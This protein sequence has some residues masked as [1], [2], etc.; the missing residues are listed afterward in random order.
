MSGIFGLLRR[1]GGPADPSW[2]SAMQAAMAFYG[3]DGQSCWA[4]GCVGLGFLLKEV[5]PEDRHER[6]PYRVPRGHVVASARL[7]NRGALLE[8]FQ[9]PGP[10]ASTTPDGLL[11]ALAFDRWG[12]DCPQHLEGD[13][14]LAGWDF[15]EQRL[16]LARDGCGLTSLYFL[17]GPGYFA[18][19]S[20]LK[21]LLALP[22]VKKAPD[23]LRMAQVLVA[24][25][26]DEELTAYEACHR[27]PFGVAM[28]VDTQGQQKSWR[29]WEPW[30]RPPLDYAKDED[31]VEAF[32]EHYTRAVRSRLRGTGPVAA[33]LSAGM[34]SGSV[35]ALAAPL[36]AAQGR[37]L[38]AY[39]SVPLHPPDGAGPTR[40]GNEWEVAHLTAGLAGSNVHH[41][42]M[43]AAHHTVLEGIRYVLGVHDGPGHASANHYW[44]QAIGE[45][46]RQDGM[47]TLLLGMF[48]NA[49]VSWTGHGSALLALKQGDPALAFRLLKL[50]LHH[51][52]ATLKRQVLSPLAYP[53]RKLQRQRHQGRQ[54]PW[55]SYAAIRAEFALQQELRARMAQAGHYPDFL[56]PPW[57]DTHYRFYSHGWSP[58]NGIWTELSPSLG[59]AGLD[60]TADQAL[61]AFIWSVPDDQ[62]L[63]DGASRA[64]LRRTFKGRLPEAVLRPTG[65]GLQAADLGHRVL[66]EREA[67]R[68]VLRAL[69]RSDLAQTVLDLP[70][71]EATLEAL[72]R[73]VTPESTQAAACILLRGLGVGLF[74]LQFEGGDSPQREG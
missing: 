19:A 24:W 64:L 74:L 53:V 72:E 68:E 12:R 20:S 49:S 41:V 69:A 48:G 1:D 9:V 71:M 23:L 56:F 44:V 60:P 16:L 27:L 57:H 11:A 2:L 70:R 42:P 3:P 13:W 54:Q 14:A 58:A 29:H 52:W 37:G 67:M 38:T 35:V 66:Q 28:E 31:Y 61:N 15:Q 6:Q 46:A 22:G 30:G 59:I 10:E 8:A 33:T 65:K 47:R 26:H 36:L 5:N 55:T 63:L 43:D 73:G 34:D 7:D 39:T 17:N 18:F 51:P 25:Q 45:R 40:F 4:E 32:L 62:F 50:G 21:A